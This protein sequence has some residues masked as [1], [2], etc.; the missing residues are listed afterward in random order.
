AAK[1]TS[2]LETASRSGQFVAYL[3]YMMAAK[4]DRFNALALAQE[5]RAVEPILL[6]LKSPVQPGSSN[7][8]ATLHD[9]RQAVGGFLASLAPYSAFDTILGSAKVL[10]LHTR[11]SITT[12]SITGVRSSELSPKPVSQLQ[13]ANATL[14]PIKCA[15]QVVISQE[16]ARLQSQE[17]SQ[18]I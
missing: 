3:K 10:P 4:G 2:D 18:L 5:R 16:L 8:L 7:S 9:Y 15:A 17:A 13:L 1:V 12:Q 6:M 14:E 11:I